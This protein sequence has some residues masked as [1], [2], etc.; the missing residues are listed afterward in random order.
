M[1]DMSM[2][3]L[4]GLVRVRAA[5]VPGAGR[6]PFLSRSACFSMA[7]SLFFRLLTAYP[8]GSQRFGTPENAHV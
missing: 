5:S 1:S 8:N 3:A 7:R 2:G 6:P 4:L